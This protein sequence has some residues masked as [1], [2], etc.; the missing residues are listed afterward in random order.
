M[1]IRVVKHIGSRL[2][3]ADDSKVLALIPTFPGER[4]VNLDISAYFACKSDDG[5]DQPSELNWYGL[6]VPWPI[7]WSTDLLK[8]TTEDYDTVA[9]YDSLYEMWTRS[10]TEVATKYWGGDVDADPEDQAVEEG[11]GEDA[12]LDSGPIGVHTWFT[13]KTVMFPMAAE[14]NDKIR[15]GDQFTAR[16]NNLPRASFGALYMFGI[17]RSVAAA[18]TNFNIELDDAVPKE[19]MGL[20]MS[21]DYP[22]V[23]AMVQGNTAALGDFLRTVLWGG[24]AYI[25][26]DSLKGSS[27]RG[28]IKIRAAIS[29]PLSRNQ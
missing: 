18:E 19:A 5:I 7:F 15:F 10:A 2:C 26:A 17:F 16:L 29:S 6:I 27:G 11:A 4:I 28:T 24:D 22:R 9:D 1:G 8:A 13:R 21:G 14:G 25:E 20:L 3:P 23:E 12:L